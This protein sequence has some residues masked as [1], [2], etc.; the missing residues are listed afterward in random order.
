MRQLLMLLVAAVVVGCSAGQRAPDFTL[1][2]DDGTL[3]TLSQQR[4]AVL[5]TFGFTHC[6]DT[7]PATVAKLAQLGGRLRGGPR[8]IEVAFVT[9]DPARD[10]VSV[11]RRFVARFHEAG[12]APVIGLTGTSAQIEHVKAIYHVWSARMAHDIAHTAAIFLIDSRGR[13]RGVRDDDDS[14]ASLARA[15][16]EMLS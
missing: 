14:Q 6:A 13:I 1:R 7:C 16:A 3:W 11:M 2:A 9:V 8:S 15:V 12:N 10:T 5:L 4:T